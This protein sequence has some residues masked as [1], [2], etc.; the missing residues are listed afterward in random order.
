MKTIKNQKFERVENSE[1]H[2]YYWA[3]IVVCNEMKEKQ[4][5]SILLE[6]MYI[7]GTIGYYLCLRFGGKGYSAEIAKIRISGERTIDEVKS[8][9]YK[10]I[11]LYEKEKEIR[12]PGEYIKMFRTK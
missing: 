7:G 9:F 1:F 2:I 5:F 6:K 11:K 4:S 12:K 3:P 10:V 8:F